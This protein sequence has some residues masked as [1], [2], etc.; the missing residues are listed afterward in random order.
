MALFVDKS[1]FMLMG[2]QM[3]SV[4]NVSS[5]VLSHANE[6]IKQ[7]DAHLAVV[8]WQPLSDDPFGVTR[9]E[10]SLPTLNA[11]AQRNLVQGMQVDFVQAWSGRPVALAA[12]DSPE[13]KYAA[14]AGV[15]CKTA[16]QS[17][18][19]IASQSAEDGRATLDPLHVMTH[20]VV[21]AL[22]INLGLTDDKMRSAGCACR[23]RKC[24]LSPN[25]DPRRDLPF[26][27]A[28]PELLQHVIGSSACAYD[29]VPRATHI[30]VCYNG[31][32]EEGEQCDCLSNFGHDPQQDK[33]NTCCRNCR[34]YRQYT[35]HVCGPTPAPRTPVRPPVPPTAPPTPPPVAVTHT[36][37]ATAPAPTPAPT[38]TSTPSPTTEALTSPDAET[39]E[40]RLEP[41]TEPLPETPSPSR[42]CYSRRDRDT[43]PSC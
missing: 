3:G 14:Y 41:E 22:A 17:I 24:V 31:I 39:T 33:C 40:T 20:Y 34:Q 16:A 7:L 35:Q 27:P 12:H 2:G 9:L 26:L 37:P 11:V 42:S 4:A 43:R 29:P 19:S 10:L 23:T 18:L 30:A 38:Q 25:T 5:R 13:L 32:L 15:F 28:C 1:A 36:R 21:R 8:H 6:F